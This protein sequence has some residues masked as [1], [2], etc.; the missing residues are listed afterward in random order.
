MTALFVLLSLSFLFAVFQAIHSIR[1][2]DYSRDYY[3][4]EYY[5]SCLQHGDYAELTRMAN[6][7]QRLEDENSKT[8]RQ[9]QAAGFYYQ[10]AVLH[11]AFTD[12]GMTEKASNQAKLMEK[13]QEEMGDLANYAE[14][15]RAKAENL[16]TKG[17]S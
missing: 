2:V 4:E 14:D 16:H 17:E 6:Q 1:E 10:S 5:L 3:T 13:Y 9:C 11:Q 12:A 8:I 15:I 7:D